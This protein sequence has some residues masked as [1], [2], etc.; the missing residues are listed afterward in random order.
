MPPLL[1]VTVSLV[2]KYIRKCLF[3]PSEM[4]CNVP[5][6][7]ILLAGSSLCSDSF[8]CAALYMFS[9]KLSFKEP[10]EEA[11]FEFQHP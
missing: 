11:Q 1:F 6:S 8:P 10:I 9:R 7:N 5:G 2:G 4:L 3:K